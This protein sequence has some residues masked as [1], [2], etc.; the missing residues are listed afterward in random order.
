MPDLVTLYNVY[1]HP[2][3]GKLSYFKTFLKNTR[4]D[5]V[6]ST[7]YVATT[8]WTRTVTANLLVDP[9]TTQQYR[10]GT[11]GIKINK[12]FMEFAAWDALSNADRDRFWTLREGD[13]IVHLSSNGESDAVSVAEIT[14]LNPRRINSINPILLK[15]G[16]LHHWE[17][18]LV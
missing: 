3:T 1:R 4:L 17:V 15:N 12:K 9:K 14:A 7:I 16:V 8:G 13:C 18:N 2:S 5:S 10:R 6:S 11:G